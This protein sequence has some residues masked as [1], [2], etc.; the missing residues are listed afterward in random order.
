[1][2]FMLL[3]GHIHMYTLCSM[4]RTKDQRVFRTTLLSL[5][6]LPVPSCGPPGQNFYAYWLFSVP[7]PD[8]WTCH[9]E[10]GLDKEGP[11]MGFF[12]E[13]K[14]GVTS[15]KPPFLVDFSGVLQLKTLY[16]VL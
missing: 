15:F 3:I 8:G 2:H 7:R 12:S 10:G 16:Q 13:L 4:R 6:H 1:M 14:A 9:L 11:K 5:A